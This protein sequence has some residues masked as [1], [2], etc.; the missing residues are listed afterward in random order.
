M[1]PQL[2]LDSDK[3]RGELTDYQVTGSKDVPQEDR[4]DR[5][6]DLVRTE[7]RLSQVASLMKALSALSPQREPAW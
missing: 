6:W 7:E 1:S 5:F 4:V 2:W 3:L